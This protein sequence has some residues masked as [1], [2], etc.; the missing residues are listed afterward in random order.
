MRNRWIMLGWQTSLLAILLAVTGISVAQER[1]E[2]RKG[3]DGPPGRGRFFGGGSPVLMTL[4][5]PEVQKSLT[6]TDEEKAFIKLLE[7]EVADSSRKFFEALSQDLTR[8]ERFEKS[9]TWMQGRQKETE[10]QLAE[11]IG[12]DRVKRLNQ[13]HLQLSGIGMSLFNPEVS[14]KLKLT[15]E[16]RTRIFDIGRESRQAIGEA[17]RSEQSE[18]ERGKIMAESRKKSEEGILSVLTDSQKRTWKELTGEPIDFPPP[19]PP[20][21]RFERRRDGNDSG[22]R[23]GR[24][25]DG[26]ERRKDDPEKRR[27]TVNAFGFRAND[28]KTR[29]RPGFFL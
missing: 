7:E 12:K 6:V 16:Q 4:N 21:F 27:P 26:N 10:K 18:E 3:K 13:I 15:E 24:R 29:R 14:E 1:K 22:D 9:R 19:R 5:Y 11:I 25:R 17:M 20:M 28:D 23:G 2:Q 8:E